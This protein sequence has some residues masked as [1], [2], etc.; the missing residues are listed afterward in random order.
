MMKR[1]NG[2]WLALLLIIFATPSLA[3]DYSQ[4]IAVDGTYE[5]MFHHCGT[6]PDG[7]AT[8][9]GYNTIAP[10]HGS[11]SNGGTGTLSLAQELADC[12]T[13]TGT[14]PSE[15]VLYTADSGYNGADSFQF[16]NSETTINDNYY[17]AIG[18]DTGDIPSSVVSAGKNMISSVNFLTKFI[19]IR[20]AS[21]FRRAAPGVAQGQGGSPAAISSAN[22]LIDDR[23]DLS[24]SQNRLGISAGDQIDRHGMWGNLGYTSTD[25]TNL[26]TASDSS[27]YTVVAGYDYM[28]TDTLAMGTAITYENMDEDSQYNLGSAQTDGYS[29]APYLSWMVTDYLSFD[30]IAGY[31][32]V[33]YEQDRASGTITS[34][35]DAQRYFM[36]SAINNFYYK[37]NW[38]FV[39]NLAYLFA[40]ESQE[41]FTESN[42]TVIPENKIDIAQFTA[43]LEVAY[44]F[45]HVEPYLL[46][47]FEYDAKYDAVLGVDY[48]RTGG[49]VGFGLRMNFLDSLTMDI[50]GASK[51]AR[52]NFNE[53]SFQGNLRYAF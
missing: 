46:L 33:S 41:G 1:L 53:Y 48:D 9:L 3:A 13:T 35:L 50:N 22:D 45:A 27:L 31:T 29:L 19:S 36:Q 34:S 10:A 32:F 14:I 8:N 11:F 6:T 30:L 26:V 40:H 18:I 15:I 51:F 23:I 4:S 28:L 24:I 52:A 43:G 39:A 12:G 37:D 49:D 44:G 5:V 21:I 47:A 2:V 38:T 16:Y 42:T 20:T 25:D 7:Y 17:L